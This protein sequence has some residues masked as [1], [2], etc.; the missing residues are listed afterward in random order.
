MVA[1]HIIKQQEY[2]TLYMF[3]YVESIYFCEIMK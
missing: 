2:Y 3:Y 1:L